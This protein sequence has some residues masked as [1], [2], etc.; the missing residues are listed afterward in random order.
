M[1][2]AAIIISAVL[3]FAGVAAAGSLTGLGQDDTPTIETPT[4][5]TTTGDDVR[6]EDRREAEDR[7]RANE[8]GED[9]RGPCDEAEHATD[10]RCTGAQDDRGRDDDDGDRGE[11]LRG[12]CDEAEH[13]TDPRCTG[14]QDDRGREDDD[15]RGEDRSGPSGNSGPGNAEDRGGD[16]DSGHGGN[17]GRGGG[18]D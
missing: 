13:A 3:L 9:L 8:P 12:P 17:S 6:G 4:L 5:S 11:D 18:D 1:T 15:D 2:K 7:G 14:A 10:P 16:D